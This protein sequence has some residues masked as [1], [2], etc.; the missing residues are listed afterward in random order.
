MENTKNQG[1]EEYEEIS[2]KKTSKLGYLLLILLGIFLFVVG[3]NVFNDIQNIPERP[4]APNQ[5]IEG[6]LDADNLKNLLDSSN[7]Y[8]YEKSRIIEENQ[9]TTPGL[10]EQEKTLITIKTAEFT[11]IDKKFG[12]DKNFSEIEPA[13]NN[14]LFLNK[15]LQKN[16]EDLNEKNQQMKELL[17]Q[18]GLSLQEIMAK[19][20]TLMDK[21]EIKSQIILLNGE[22]SLLNKKIS[23]EI[24]A[25]DEKIESIRPL[26]LE[27]KALYKSAMENYKD[28]VAKY[29]FIVFLLK[30]L[31]VLPFFCISLYFYFKLHRKNSPNTIIVASILTASSALFMEIIVIFLYQILPTEWLQRIFKILK[32][33][34]ALK[35]II[36]YSSAI[37]VII[38]FGGIVYIIQKKV[39]NPK[40]IAI[41]RLK[42]SK[43]PNCSFLISQAYDFCPKCGRDIKEKC[44]NC[45]NQRTKDLPFCQFCGNK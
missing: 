44:Q 39:F 34:A 1:V 18:Y 13:L 40:L 41:R 12:L 35:Y 27:T 7:Y 10:T 19:E 33:F 8:V 23:E 45:G 5:S 16:E 9:P 21:P 2:E 15:N 31:F 26:L 4:I 20:E 42:E 6:Y 17:G 22:I 24:L 36:Y 37:L 43:C 30:L 14:I 25:R 29:N 28:S 11:A 3:Q 38:L 32:E